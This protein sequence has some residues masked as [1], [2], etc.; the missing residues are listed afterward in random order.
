MKIETALITG[1]SSGIG[2]ELARVFAQAGHRLVLTAPVQAELDKIAAEFRREHGVTVHAIAADLET[3]D[4]ADRLFAAV[5]E[6]DLEITTLVNN[7]GRGM[8]GRFTDIPVER[9]IEMIRLNIEAVVRLTKKFLPDMIQRKRGRLLFTASI[10]SFEP[11]PLLAVYHATKAFVLS[12]SEALATELE[13][14]GLTVTALCP[15]PSDTDFFPKADMVETRAFQKA[16]VMAPQEVAR[17]GF[18]AA[19][20]GERVV[21]PGGMNKAMVFARRL[22]TLSTQAKKNQKYYEEVDAEDHTREP[23]DIASAKGREQPPPTSAANPPPS[24]AGTPR[25]TS[26]RALLIDELEDLLDAERQLLQALPRMADAAAHPDLKEAFQSHLAET[27]NH[28]ERLARIFGTLGAT[29]KSKTCHAMR[30]LIEEGRETIRTDAPESLRDAKLIGAAQ[31]VEHY[32][33]AAY[34]TARAF[35]ETLGETGVI[36]LLQKTLSEESTADEKLTAI[37]SSINRDALIE[38]G[39]TTS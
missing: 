19:M 18:D 4:A 22:T 21:V 20:K 7:A 26:L 34:G 14:S 17:A 9:D 16:N 25:M 32:E 10:A 36:A 6:R 35:A 29:A 5:K 30:G 24:A 31:R 8:R 37:A 12:F 15:G 1:A 11:G 38:T 27:E 13:D 23:G 28:V 39:G 3:E 33:I 2:L